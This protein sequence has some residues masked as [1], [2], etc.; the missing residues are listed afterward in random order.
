MLWSILITGF[1]LFKPVLGSLVFSCIFVG[2]HKHIKNKYAQ[3]G[4]MIVVGRELE[5][6]KEKREGIF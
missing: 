1:G 4:K 3:L 2:F 5:Q 6:E